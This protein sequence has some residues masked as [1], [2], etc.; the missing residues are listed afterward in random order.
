MNHGGGDAVKEIFCDDAIIFFHLPKTSDNRLPDMKTSKT[1][2]AH[3]PSLGK[4]LAAA[5]KADGRTVS[6]Y[7]RRVLEKDLSVS[8]DAERET[9]PKTLKFRGL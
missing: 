9:S 4:A 6:S 1:T 8:R 3:P 5:A 2:F 7:I